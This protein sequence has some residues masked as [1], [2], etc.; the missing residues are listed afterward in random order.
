M[1][2]LVLWMRRLRCISSPIGITLQTEG[3]CQKLRKAFQGRGQ[4]RTLHRIKVCN[5]VELSRIDR[6]LQDLVLHLTL[7]IEHYL[8]VRID[9]GAMA[10]GCNVHSLFESRASASGG[11]DAE[12]FD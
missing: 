6:Q 3:L 2:P 7:D 12:Y 8:K 4:E 10:E 1:S 9:R 11:G 5:L